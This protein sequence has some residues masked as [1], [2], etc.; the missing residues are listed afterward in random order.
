[1]TINEYGN[2]NRLTL[3]LMKIGFSENKTVY[4]GIKKHE[5]KPL[6]PIISQFLNKFINNANRNHFT[7]KHSLF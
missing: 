1:M 5:T 4:R 7:L 6:K 3:P 2:V